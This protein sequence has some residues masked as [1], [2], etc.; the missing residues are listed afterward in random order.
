MGLTQRYKTVY[1]RISS[2]NT[3]IGASTMNRTDYR[4]NAYYCVL[5]SAQRTA[6]PPP[7]HCIQLASSS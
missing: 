5:F 2:S 1:K 7:P 4:V 6:P 3:E